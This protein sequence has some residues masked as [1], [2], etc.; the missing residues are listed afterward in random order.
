MTALF[1]AAEIAEIQAL[2][3]E[4]LTQPGVT[5]VFAVERLSE[6]ATKGRASQSWTATGSTVTGALRRPAPA[7]V[8][9]Y[10]QQQQHIS[11]VLAAVPGQSESAAVAPN[12]VLVSG[13]RRFW[14]VDV[15]GQSWL[16]LY[17]RLMLDERHGPIEG[18][19]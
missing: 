4:L 11:H 16:G 9:A 15:L 12:D 14:V 1:N 13:G 17:T 6:S 7:D 18:A 3:D 2:A 5:L 8:A 19:A 10:S